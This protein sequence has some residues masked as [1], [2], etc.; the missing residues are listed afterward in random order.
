MLAQVSC[1]F[2]LRASEPWPGSLQPL[3]FENESHAPDFVFAMRKRL[4]EQGV[5]LG[6]GGAVL[7]IL[8]EQVVRRASSLDAEG[9]AAEYALGYRIDVQLRDA[10][11]LIRLNRTLSYTR[12]YA[13]DVAN[14]VGHERQDRQLV[15]AMRQQA[16]DE[17]IRQV[18]VIPAVEPVQ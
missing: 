13:F 14:T 15:V 2:H 8:A 5:A 18:S 3:R 1:G 16:I 12:S 7:S 17:L 9:K 4:L 10:S 6:D 11:N